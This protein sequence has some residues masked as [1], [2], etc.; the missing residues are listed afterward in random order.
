MKDIAISLVWFNARNYSWHTLSYYWGWYGYL[1][2]NDVG[3]QLPSFSTSMHSP[4]LTLHH[5]TF[6]RKNP[7]FFSELSMTRS[8]GAPANLPHRRNRSPPYPPASV[9]I[10]TN[11]SRHGYLESHQRRNPNG[12]AEPY[13]HTPPGVTSVEAT[14]SGCF[15]RNI[16][17]FRIPVIT[18]IGYSIKTVSFKCHLSSLLGSQH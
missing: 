13:I 12:T 4:I 14:A 15:S 2:M 5:S 11:H 1:S 6:Q 10:A 17:S 16:L 7:G 3:Q 9:K 8:I 18:V